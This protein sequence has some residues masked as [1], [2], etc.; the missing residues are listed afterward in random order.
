VH[1]MSDLNN[2]PR[3]H[4][5]GRVRTCLRNGV[6]GDADGGDAGQGF[7]DLDRPQGK[8]SFLAWLAVASVTDDP[9]GDLIDDLRRDPRKP[10]DIASRAAL[11]SYLVS[12]RACREALRTVPAVWR[13][14]EAGV[15]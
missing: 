10:A 4:G 7:V 2:E 1:K 6:V 12:R 11:R 8:L 15:G 5:E 13:R 3:Q 14:F 9:A